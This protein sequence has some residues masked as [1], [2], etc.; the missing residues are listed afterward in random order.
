MLE[1]HGLKVT[2]DGRELL[3]TASARAV[4]VAVDL[5]RQEVVI[6]DHRGAGVHVALTEGSV[7]VSGAHTAWEN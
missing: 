5:R 6:D 4:A 7:L 3:P 2:S 1:M